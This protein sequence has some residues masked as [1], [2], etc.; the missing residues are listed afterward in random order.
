MTLEGR[1]D[2]KANAGAGEVAGASNNV[3]KNGGTNESKHDVSVG[4]G[5]VFDASEKSCEICTMINPV[6]A[7]ECHMCYTK[8]QN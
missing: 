6:A 7:T 2:S 5:A 8:F 4:N 1:S 3:N